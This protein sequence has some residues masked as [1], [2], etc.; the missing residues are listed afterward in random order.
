MLR[1]AISIL[2]ALL[3][4]IQ[5]WQRRQELKEQQRAADSLADNPVEWY[6]DHFNGVRGDT[7]DAADKTDADRDKQ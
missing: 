1:T 2:S 3:V 5:G 7:T 6:N 4:I